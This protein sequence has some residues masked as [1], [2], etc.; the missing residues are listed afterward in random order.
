MGLVSPTA[1]TYRHNW[2]LFVSWKSCSISN[3]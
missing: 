2:W 3:L 1:V